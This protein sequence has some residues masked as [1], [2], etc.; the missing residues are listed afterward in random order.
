MWWVLALLS[1]MAEQSPATGPYADGIK[2][3]EAKDY[4]AAVELFNKVIAGEPKDYTAHFNLGFA[5]SMQE[6][7]GD[8]IAQYKIVLELKPGLYD[9]QLNLGM[10][11]YREKEFD[12]AIEQL[13]AAETQKPAELRPAYYLGLAFTATGKLAEAESELRKA[14]S[15]DAQ[16]KQ[17]LLPLGEAY[18]KAGDAQKAIAIYKEFPGDA[19]AQE[20]MGALLA[21]SGDVSDAIPALEEAVAK[22]P[23]VANRVALAQAYLKEKQFD[24]ADPQVAQAVASA[25]GDFDLRMFYGR[26]LRDQ[27]KFNE[28]A[29]QFLAASKL[30]PDAVAP[31]NEI[32]GVMIASEQYPQALAA[33]DRVHA[34][35]GDTTAHIYLRAISLDHLHVL[36][37]ALANYNRFLEL[38]QGKSPDEEFKAKQRARIIQNELNKR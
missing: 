27:R 8:A 15:I 37:D 12:A 14:A 22:S 10:C 23:T 36:K 20:R 1:V 17:A 35:G 25:P 3:L 33:L 29:A 28:A 9:A 19:G 21:K 4:P 32:T 18:E 31:W 34:L 16:Y 24:K 2:A 5:Y 26:V 7:Y 11:L 30:K 6:K 13:K 38:S